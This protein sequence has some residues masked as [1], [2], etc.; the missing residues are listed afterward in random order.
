M[1]RT[2][3]GVRRYDVSSSPSLNNLTDEGD[4][5]QTKVITE[6]GKGLNR[7]GG[8]PRYGYKAVRNSRKRSRRYRH[9]FDFYKSVSSMKMKKVRALVENSS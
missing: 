7:S 2:K 1:V 8:H 5:D 6:L 9:T 3:A 4:E